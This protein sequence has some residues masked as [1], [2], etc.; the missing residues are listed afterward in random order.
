MHEK[1]GCVSTKGGCMPQTAHT[2]LPHLVVPHTRNLVFI[3][4][5]DGG[6]SVGLCV[7]L[8]VVGFLVGVAVGL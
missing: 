1:M 7:G 4:L 8:C 2:V 6:M 5:S 3:E